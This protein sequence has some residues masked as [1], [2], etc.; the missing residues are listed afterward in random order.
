MKQKKDLRSKINAIREEARALR[1]RA[2]ELE[3]LIPGLEYMAWMSGQGL[4]D[5]EI[6]SV[7]R[8]GVDT[9]KEK[10]T[11][12]PAVRRKTSKIKG[13]K[14]KRL[15]LMGKTRQIVEIILQARKPQTVMMIQK[16][17][18]DS[19]ENSVRG[20]V[21]QLIRRK[22]LVSPARGYY[23]ATPAAI[24][25]LE[26]TAGKA[27]SGAASKPVAKPTAKPAAKAAKPVRT[28]RRKARRA[29]AQKAS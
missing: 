5:A 26:K 19:S 25:L 13:A 3:S 1:Q 6:L 10:H 15:V 23:V 14:V 17:L 11:V 12:A 28:A 9:K 21:Y 16:H 18:P 24:E 4:S 7:G 27:S 8:R 22:L 29:K 20:M 2:E